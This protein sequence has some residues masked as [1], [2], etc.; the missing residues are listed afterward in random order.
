MA[1]MGVGNWWFAYY[2]YHWGSSTNNGHADYAP[3]V[4]TTQ[5]VQI[6]CGLK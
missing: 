5:K 3:W 4:V 1:T 2:A 6:Y